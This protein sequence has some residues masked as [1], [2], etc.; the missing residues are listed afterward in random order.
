MGEAGD[1]LTG[2]SAKLEELLKSGEAAP[3]LEP[4]LPAAEPEAPIPEA[5]LMEV[6]E[7]AGRGSWEDEVGAMLEDPA[8]KT[9]YESFIKQPGANRET[10]MI[11]A[12]AAHLYKDKLQTMGRAEFIALVKRIREALA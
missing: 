4:E 3:A 1:G 5:P 6:P 8:A 11:I 9:A 7:K 12:T 2:L 10:A